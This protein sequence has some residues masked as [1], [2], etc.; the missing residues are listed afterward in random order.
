MQKGRP[1]LDL[2]TEVIAAEYKAGS[3]LAVLA[4]KYGCG[5]NTIKTRIL[6]EGVEIRSENRGRK[7][8]VEVVKNEELEKPASVQLKETFDEKIESLKKDIEETKPKRRI[9]W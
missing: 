9:G 1:R 8:K 5:V 6:E 3:S 7:K 2:P 4:K